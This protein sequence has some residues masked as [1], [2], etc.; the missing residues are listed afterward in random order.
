MSWKIVTLE[1]YKRFVKKEAKEESVIS[2]WLCLHIFGF[3]FGTLSVH[4]ADKSARE[5][6]A[7]A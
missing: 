3:R 6:V 1:N 2:Y 7:K 4:Y 5:D